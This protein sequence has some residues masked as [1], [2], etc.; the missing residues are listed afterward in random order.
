MSIMFRVICLLVGF[1]FSLCN[2]I[3]QLCKLMKRSWR[4]WWNT[5]SRIKAGGERTQ[6]LTDDS[7]SSESL[8]LA[9][10]LSERVCRRWFVCSAALMQSCRLMFTRKDSECDSM[11]EQCRHDC[12][13]TV[14]AESWMHTERLCSRYFRYESVTSAGFCK[15]LQLQTWCSRW[16]PIETSCIKIRWWIMQSCSQNK[17]V[18]L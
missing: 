12:L 11:L 4:N 3:A 9:S 1:I 10:G 7:F 15:Q 13:T 2:R 6:R 14:K 17:S 16:C 8:R 5:R 18:E